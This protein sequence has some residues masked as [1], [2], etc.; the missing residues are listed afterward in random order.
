LINRNGFLLPWI[1]GTIAVFNGSKGIFNF[2]DVFTDFSHPFVC[3]GFS[4]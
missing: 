3:F 1:D 4:I 2:F